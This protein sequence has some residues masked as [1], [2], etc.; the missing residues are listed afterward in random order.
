[1]CSVTKFHRSLKLGFEKFY[2]LVRNDG[3]HIG[4]LIESGKSQAGEK[5]ENQL[6]LPAAFL[7]HSFKLTLEFVQLTIWRIGT[8]KTTN[9]EYGSR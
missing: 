7:L 9:R 1:M 6:E 2:R 8:A 4:G 5:S 3:K